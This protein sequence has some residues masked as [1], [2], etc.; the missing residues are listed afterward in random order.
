ME[1]QGMELAEARKKRK[2]V[3]L[4]GVFFGLLLVLTLF[5]NTLQAITLPKVRTETPVKG[6]L[7]HSIEANGTLK[8]V[9]E[10]ELKN[11]T[12]WKVKAVHVKAGDAVVKDQPL[13]TYDS[14]PA[15]RQIADEQS[16]LKQQKLQLDGLF[17]SF[18]EANRNGDSTAISKAKRD[19]E[20]R[21]LD[22]DV[23]ERKIQAL[24]EDLAGQR[25][26][27][28]PFDGIVT[29]VRAT[30]GLPS[31]SGQ[32][33]VRVSNA[34]R[35]YGM[36][37]LVAADLAAF[38]SVGEKIEVEVKDQAVQV[39]EGRID[40]IADSQMELAGGAGQKQDAPPASKTVRITVQGEGL[41]GG[42]RAVVR[43]QKSVSADEQLLISNE[44]VHKDQEGKFVY[45]IEER[46]GPLGNGFYVRK[47]YI[48][49][50]DGNANQTAVREGIFPMDQVIVESGEPLQ[51]GNRVRLQ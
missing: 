3:V 4:S 19:I 35:G 11:E 29:S 51:A 2:M 22:I 43:L 48:R 38:L 20:S 21:Q 10:A 45:V 44:A 6:K 7:V 25:Q 41:N 49:A 33:V 27:V 9:E 31:L 13:I 37:V 18:V 28:A 14:K 39:M 16:A 24:Q 36:S 23:R 17:E 46:K 12:G 5:S 32:P 34:S 15:D 40:E 26:I 47:S 30:E 8:P 50:A 1:L 42:E